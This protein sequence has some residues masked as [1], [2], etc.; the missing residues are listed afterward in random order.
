M[1]LGSFFF[2]L[3]PLFS[4]A[5]YR[6]F[7]LQLRNPANEVVKEFPSTLDP[8]QYPTYFSIPQGFF[9]TYSDTWMCRG[10]TNE[11]QLCPNP[12]LTSP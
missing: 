11:R 3:L 4:W 9:L 2:F 1:K 5:E 8:L 12:K 7:Q 10:R 6:V